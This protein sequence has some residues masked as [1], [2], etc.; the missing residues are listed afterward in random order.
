MN[1]I[2]ISLRFN[3]NGSLYSAAKSKILLHILKDNVMRTQ[4]SVKPFTAYKT[5]GGQA[6]MKIINSSY[7][8]LTEDKIDNSI[9]NMEKNINLTQFKKN[10]IDFFN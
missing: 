2:F 5:K 3:G 4:L 9:V 7:F 8:K 1:G 10:V 6:L